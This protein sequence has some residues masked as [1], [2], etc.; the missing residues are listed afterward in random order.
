VSM[1]GQSAALAPA[2]RRI[3]ALRDVTATVECIPLIVASILSKKLA[4]GIDGLVLDVKVGRGAFM[5][6]LKS[7]RALARALVR[8]GSGAGKRVV[9]LLTDMD[10]PI[11]RTIGNALET[12]EAIEI[13][14]NRGPADTRELTLTLGAEMLVLG[15]AERS[16]P[17]ARARLARALSDGSALERFL[18]M[19]RAHGGDVRAVEDPERLPRAKARALV[20]APRAGF[21]TDCDAFLLGSSAVRLGAGRTRAEQAVDA[22]AGIELC[23]GRGERVTRGQPI[24]VIHARSQGLAQSEVAHVGAAFRISARAPQARRVVLERIGR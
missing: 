6:D 10:G 1:I 5:K 11:G 4:E 18:R 2:D 20:L 3:Y 14:N 13:L 15:K 23:A 17:A 16:L 7:A 19:V 24:A 22:S 21:V 9:A 12:R 8:V